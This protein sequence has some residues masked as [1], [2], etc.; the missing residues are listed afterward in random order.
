MKLEEL[1]VRLRIEEDNR[2]SEIRVV[3]G[4]GMHVGLF[5]PLVGLYVTIMCC[6]S[7]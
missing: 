7:K 3:G 5:N 1:I 6:P 4:Q 2:K